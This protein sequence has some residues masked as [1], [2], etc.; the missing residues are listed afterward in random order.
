MFRASA[1]GGS[2]AAMRSSV[3]IAVL[4]LWAVSACCAARAADFVATAAV[5]QASLHTGFYEQTGRFYADVTVKNVG[6]SPQAIIVWT[7][8]QAGRGSPTATR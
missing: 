4:M 2:D 6:T 5:D 1:S 3:A 7:N 8:P